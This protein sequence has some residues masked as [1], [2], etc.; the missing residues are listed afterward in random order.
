L[1]IGSLRT[2]AEHVS[3]AWQLLQ[4]GL[5]KLI[6]GDQRSGSDSKTGEA[7]GGS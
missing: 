4:A 5:V 1:A 2:E 7:G 6:G 3:Q